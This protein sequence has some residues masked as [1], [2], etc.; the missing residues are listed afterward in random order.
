MTR[1]AHTSL[2]TRSIVAVSC[3]VVSCLSAT[4]PARA[5][6]QDI[7]GAW[8]MSVTLRNCA[9]N[10]AL[11]PPFLTLITFHAGGT[12]SESAASAGFAPGQRG[13]GHGSWRRTGSSTFAGQFVALILFETAP[14]LPVTPGFKAGG[15]LV[16]SSFTLT[17]PDQLAATASAAFYDAALAPYRT[18]CPTIVGQRLR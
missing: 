16:N 3:L 14:N 15:V 1:T 8:L 6:A 13:P 7:D 17:G 11:G 9:T 12:L 10:V 2:R 4:L 5:E 18:A